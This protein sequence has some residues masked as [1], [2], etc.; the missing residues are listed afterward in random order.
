MPTIV[1][2]NHCGGSLQIPEHGLGKTLKCPLCQGTFQAPAA[3]APPPPLAILAAPVAASQPVVLI[4]CPHCHRSL[5]ALSSHLGRTILCPLCKTAFTAV[6]QDGSGGLGDVS[7][8]AQHPAGAT[9]T[10]ARQQTTQHSSPF[11]VILKNDPQKKLKGQFQ[12]TLT[13]RGLLLKKGKQPDILIPIGTA[14]PAT[15]GGEIK[16]PIDD[17]TVDCTVF[18]FSFDWFS[19]YWERLSRDI[20]AFLRGERSCPRLSEY[21]MPW[22]LYAPASLPLP[23]LF[24]TMR[25]GLMPA[26]IGGA[27]GG[28]FA[29]G[30]LAVARSERWPMAARLAAVWGLVV[31]SYLTLTAAVVF[32]LVPLP[33]GSVTWERL[34]P[35]EAH[36]SIEMPGD[37]SVETRSLA[38]ATSDM[39]VWKVVL[40]AQDAGF[41][42]HYF[43]LAP[44]LA[45]PFDCREHILGEFPKA[46]VE[47]EVEVDQ[48]GHELHFK[49]SGQIEL[50]RRY[51]K[52]NA[53]VY[54]VT[55]SSSRFAGIAADAER[56]FGSFRL[57]D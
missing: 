1:A 19:L 50:V 5:K 10:P 53:R 26:A 28:G 47:R 44:D 42:V 33:A 23:I 54:Y 41:Y 51:Y 7:Q 15:D 13:D 34:A 38:G 30:C 25:I 21:R 3:P 9:K 22:Y 4:T 11:K 14:V 37:P 2:C 49:F 55:V 48:G 39:R 6:K 24:A 17:R 35:P 36:F 8:P 27:I 56:F 32:G 57:L 46:Q 12:A 18:D 31:L 20:V 45:D 16:L 52:R 29:G 40:T 43:E